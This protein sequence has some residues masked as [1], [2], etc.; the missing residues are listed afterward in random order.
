MLVLFLSIFVADKIIYIHNFVA[1][2][3]LELESS[4][5]SNIRNFLGVDVFLDFLGRGL[6]SALH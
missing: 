5:S 2:L 3:I 4:I 6:G 1:P